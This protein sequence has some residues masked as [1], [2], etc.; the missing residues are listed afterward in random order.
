MHG[1][2]TGFWIDMFE[3]GADRIAAFDSASNDVFHLGR[4]A[5]DLSQL[6]EA[7]SAAHQNNFVHAI[8][9]LERGDGVRDDWFAAHEREQF[10]ETH[11]LAASGG[12]DDRGKHET[13]ATVFAL[14]R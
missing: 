1:N 7:I 9:A 8:G 2:E 5:D 6:I 4:F 13:R 14:R 10:V 12:V 3:S 11:S